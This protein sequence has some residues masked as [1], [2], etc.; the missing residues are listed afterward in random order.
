MN[1][2]EIR[3]IAAHPLVTIG[4]H[5]VNHYNLK[6]LSEER[7]AARDGRRQAH[8]ASAKLGEA[9]RH[10]AYP[11]GYASAV[12]CREVG[13]PS[14]AGYVS[15]VTTRHGVLR[16][17]HADHPAR[18]AAH[19]GQRPLP[20]R[21]PYPHDAVGHHHAARQC[22]ARCWS[23][24]ESTALRDQTAL[25]RRHSWK[26]ARQ[27][28]GRGSSIS[29]LMMPIAGSTHSRPLNRKNRKCT[30]GPDSASRAPRPSSRPAHRRSPGRPAGSCRSAFSGGWA[31]ALSL[32]SG[33]ASGSI[34]AMRA[35]LASRSA[36]RRVAR[37]SLASS[38]ANGSPIRDFNGTG[39]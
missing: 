31:C 12:G 4:A 10:M 16:A 8:P 21:R 29:H 6:R 23:P 26:L 28:F 35:S 30:S 37:R 27:P 19:F 36:R 20:A 3:T 11:Y 32:Q 22:A 39:P 18:A 2:D 17:E 25:G 33:I 5:T 7:G 9:P 34:G 14:E 13:L 1:W 15:A 38:A 24:S